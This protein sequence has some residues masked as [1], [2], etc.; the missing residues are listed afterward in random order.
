[1]TNKNPE[2]KRPGLSVVLMVKNEAD[3]LPRALQSVKFA[4]EII[5]AD[6]G[7]TDN[8][9][10]LAQQL[11]ANVV[12]CQ[13]QGFG[14]TKVDAL[15]HATEQWVLSLD[16]DEEITAELA[17]QI[18]H[19]VND[20]ANEYAAYR[21]TRQANFLGRWIRHSGWY[22]D[23]VVR[24]YRNGQARMSDDPVH[25]RIVTD[26]KVDTLTGILRHFTDPTIDHYLEK[27]RIYARLSA[28][29]LFAQG[30]RCH[31]WDLVVRPPFMFFK[32]YI[33]KRGFLDGWQG[34]ALA[35]FSAVHVFTKYANLKMLWVDKHNLRI[36]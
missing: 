1:M 24:L 21:L 30:R 7:S 9:M 36:P 6:T 18:R 34:L 23:Y 26:G 35:F 3:N 4:D 28:E 15:S 14:P 17:E 31:W 29:A 11:G 2:N 20:S 19:V 33:L 13:W 32:T 25:E 10:E 27:M 5:V 22:P 8:T 16:A 12:S